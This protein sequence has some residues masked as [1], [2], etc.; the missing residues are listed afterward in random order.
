M[1]AVLS[2]SV[3]FASYRAGSQGSHFQVADEAAYW[4]LALSGQLAGF[5][6]EVSLSLATCRNPSDRLSLDAVLRHPWVSINTSGILVAVTMW[7]AGLYKINFIAADLGRVV[8][9]EGRMQKGSRSTME[10][11][12]RRR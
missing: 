10:A 12:S 5:N 4:R 8:P 2:F 3:V 6:I 9:T 7:N 11:L 1:A